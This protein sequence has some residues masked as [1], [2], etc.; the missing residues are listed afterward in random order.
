MKTAFEFR[1]RLLSNGETL[2]QPATFLP[3]KETSVR[4]AREIFFPKLKHLAGFRGF[5]T[6]NHEKNMMARPL[7]KGGLQ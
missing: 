1:S 7:L 2:T 5:L 3:G 6:I 4:L